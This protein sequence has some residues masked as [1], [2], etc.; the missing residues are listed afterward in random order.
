MAPVVAQNNVRYR[1]GFIG[2]SILVGTAVVLYELGFF[3][4]LTA[5]GEIATEIIDIGASVFFF[6]VFLFFKVNY[7]KG[8]SAAKI[9]VM[10][11]CTVIEWIP[12]I[13]GFVP[14]L[15]IEV[16]A[17]IFIT[18]KEDREKAKKDAEKAAQIRARQQQIGQRNAQLQQLRAQRQQAAND[19]EQNLAAA[20]DN[21]EREREAA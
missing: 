3:L 6:I 4:M 7:F 15:V 19:N 14:A 11:A 13:N 18:R 16:V 12:F 10:G 8:R 5:I 21:E 17:I 1:I 2:G 9:G 20:N